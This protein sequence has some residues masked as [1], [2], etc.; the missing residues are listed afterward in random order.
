MKKY[1]IE[2]TLDRAEY[3][4]FSWNI[5]LTLAKFDESLA[6]SYRNLEPSILVNYLFQLCGDVSKA[7]KVLNVKGS[8]S[9]EKAV[10]RLA[11]FIASRKVL[12]YGMCILGLKPLNSM[13][14]K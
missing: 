9:E 3:D 5:V 4:I 14:E 6:L 12:N 10:L 2:H 7:I 1:E 11:L 13:W 8:D